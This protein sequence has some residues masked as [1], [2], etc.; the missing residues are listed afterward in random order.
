MFAALVMAPPALSVTPNWLL[1]DVTFAPLLNTMLLA[2]FN[3]RPALPPPVLAI[4]EATVIFPAW[5]FVPPVPVVTV[6][7]VP[8]LSAVW[9]LPVVTIALSLVDVKS[10]PPVTLVLLPAV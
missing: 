3:V 4:A 7:L 6:T 8:A 5:A 2:A 9:M 10:G 1:E